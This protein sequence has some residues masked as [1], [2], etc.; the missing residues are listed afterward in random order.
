MRS[1]IIQELSKAISINPE[2][3]NIQ[4]KAN[5]MFWM[6]NQLDINAGYIPELLR[7]KT[8]T[9]VVKMEYKGDVPILHSKLDSSYWRDVFEDT[10]T[11]TQKANFIWTLQNIYFEREEQAYLGIIRFLEGVGNK[12]SLI[13]EGEKKALSV[14]SIHFLFPSV[15]EREI[16]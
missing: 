14:L 9:E 15:M 8:T 13:S 1:K 12:N 6:L 11:E 7:G 3:V 5:K 10:F 2:E 4:Q 16:N